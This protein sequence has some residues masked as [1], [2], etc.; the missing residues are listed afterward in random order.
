[1]TGRTA[2]ATG[3]WRRLDKE[4]TDRCTLSRL[5]HGWMLVGQ[6]T[7]HED[8]MD[9]NLTYDVRCDPDW[10]SLSADVGGR[11]GDRELAL[12]LHR[13]AEGWLLNDELQDNTRDCID[14]DLCFTPATNL[15]PLRRLSLTEGQS[16]EVCAGWLRPG[17]QRIEPLEQLYSRLAPDR[18]RYSSAQFEAELELHES[19]FVTSYP[20]LWEGWVDA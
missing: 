2:I 20:G 9:A 19:G 1:M 12:R 10:V 14:L 5:D 13:T 18:V 15:L 7:W 4:G 8:G 16:A 3:H 17:F 6:A 11:I